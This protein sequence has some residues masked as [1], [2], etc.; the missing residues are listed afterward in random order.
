M[1]ELENGKA[2]L[3]AL[4]YF[5]ILLMTTVQFCL[6]RNKEKEVGRKERI[7]GCGLQQKLAE[8]DQKAGVGW[9]GSRERA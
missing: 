8:T 5:Q 6:E 9:K 4:I 7:S 3:E 1:T 2:D